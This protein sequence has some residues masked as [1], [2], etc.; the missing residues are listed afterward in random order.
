MKEKIIELFHNACALE[1]EVNEQS[2]LSMLSLDSLTFVSII[3]A[4]ENE[5]HIEFDIENLNI[6][7]WKTV[8]NIIETVEEMCSEKEHYFRG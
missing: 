2:T 4:L 5:F 6:K 1:Q 3:V 7:N 8:H